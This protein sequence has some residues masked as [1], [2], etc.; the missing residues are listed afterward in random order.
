MSLAHITSNDTQS[1]LSGAHATARAPGRAR[2]LRASFEEAGSAD[3]DA[4]QA[5]R[6]LRRA[7]VLLEEANVTAAPDEETVNEAIRLILG[8]RVKLN[9]VRHFLRAPVRGLTSEAAETVRAAGIDA[10]HAEIDTRARGLG[11]AEQG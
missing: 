2:S 6:L 11:E 3:A 9:D 1:P 7:A 8:A 5:L 10:L 4:K